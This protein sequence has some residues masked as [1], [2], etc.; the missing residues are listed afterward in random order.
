VAG[1]EVAA[2]HQPE[3]AAQEARG[4]VDVRR[5]LAAVVGDQP[6]GGGDP[7][8]YDALVAAA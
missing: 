6:P 8:A 5:D 3:T 4:L 1:G 2:E 7:S